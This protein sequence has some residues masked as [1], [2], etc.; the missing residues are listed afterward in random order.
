[1]D[2]KAMAKLAGISENEL[3][4]KSAKEQI[5]LI[6]KKMSD[7]Q[8]KIE[9][10]EAKTYISNYEKS[11][12]KLI[13][14]FEK[15]IEIYVK[16]VGQKKSPTIVSIVGYNGTTKELVA[17]YNEKHCSIPETDLIKSNDEL[18]GILN[19]KKPK[20]TRKETKGGTKK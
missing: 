2:I 13:T 14:Q 11:I 7:E 10:E 8:S 12:P 17:F 9:I 15:P 3:K 20:K 18:M 4:G 1:M 5:K 16:K 6:S 19:N